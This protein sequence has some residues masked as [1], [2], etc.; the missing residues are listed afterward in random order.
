MLQTSANSYSFESFSVCSLRADAETGSRYYNA[1]A[2][3][4]STP[5]KSYQCWNYCGVEESQFST[6]LRCIQ[7][8]T[9]STWGAACQRADQSP[10][11]TATGPYPS[12]HTPP[13]PP[14]GYTP[15]T[16]YTTDTT[17]LTSMALP[18]YTTSSISE[19]SLTP[20]ARWRMS[21]NATSTL[22]SPTSGNYGNGSNLTGLSSPTDLLQGGS[23]K[24]LTL[25]MGGI[26][27][28]FLVLSTIVL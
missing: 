24:A 28:A 3:C 10:V 18:T 19:E 12:S 15:P 25:S 20:G 21:T 26:M 1:I 4:C 5:I 17:S 16:T 11:L 22:L 27:C 9:D 23:P 6:W 14:L 13:A 7:E 8:A 2:K